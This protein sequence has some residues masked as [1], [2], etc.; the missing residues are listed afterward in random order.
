[1]NRWVIGFSI[2][3]VSRYRKDQLLEADPVAG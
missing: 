1:M 3:G 2:F